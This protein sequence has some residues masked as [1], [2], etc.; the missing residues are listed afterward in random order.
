MRFQKFIWASGIALIM[1]VFALTVQA[2]PRHVQVEGR[3][4]DLIVPPK[5]FD[6]PRPTVFVLHG[7]G[8][9]GA[10]IRKHFDFTS[11]AAKDGVVL[12]YPDAL[13]KH[14]NDGRTGERKPPK[15]PKPD[16]VA[17][18]TSIADRLIEDGVSA[19][20]K[21]YITGVSNGG[22]MTQRLL[23]DASGVF[24][25]GAS[26]IA[27]LPT[28]LEGCAPD[29]PRSILLINGDKD[30]LMPWNGGGV[31]FRHSRGLVISAA[32][33]FAHWQRL[34]GCEG[35]VSVR[36]MANI[37]KKDG[38]YAKRLTAGDCQAGHKVEQIHV[39]GGGH[40]IPTPVFLGPKPGSRRYKRRVKL[41]GAYNHDFDARTQVWQ[42]FKAEGL[43]D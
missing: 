35:K 19:P 43:L 24:Q 34:N 26:I 37:S 36:P 9:T 5:K 27:N 13:K 15:T 12:V 21:I 4:Y 7:G 42:F 18:L 31:G 14:W 2:K 30:P 10:Q 22:M 41:L 29:V 39:Y 17:F 33:T 28:T 38:T 11:R 20:N 3:S 32:R 16:D 40:N 23:C 8:G 6:G 1:S 25:A